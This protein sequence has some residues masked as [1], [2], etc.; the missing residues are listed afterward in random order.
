MKQQN[1]P[2]MCHEPWPIVWEKPHFVVVNVMNCVRL[3][4]WKQIECLSEIRANISLRH[5]IGKR[6][7]NIHPNK[8]KS[9]KNCDLLGVIDVQNK[10]EK[11]Y[12]N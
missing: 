3:L 7:C 4:G 10:F 6:E 11:S 9:F 1:L 5:G 8:M 2:H 12:M